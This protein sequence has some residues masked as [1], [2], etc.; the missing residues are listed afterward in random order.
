MSAAVMRK[1]AR[2]TL[3]IFALA[4]LGILIFESMYM[5]AMREF[6]D[7]VLRDLLARPFMQRFIRTLVGTDMGVDFTPTSLMTLGFVH[8]IVLVLTWGLLI[9]HCTRVLAGEVDRGTADIML[10]LPISRAT[11]YCS[12][13]A[14]WVLMGLAI[15][16]APITGITIGQE[17][18]PLWEPIDLGRLALITVNFAAMYLA[19]GGVATCVSAVSNTRAPAIALLIGGLLV[20]MLINFLAPFFEDTPYDWMNRIKYIGL[21]QY[22]RPLPILRS[23]ALPWLDIGVLLTVGLGAWTA[24]LLVYRRRDIPA[25]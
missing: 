16:F 3:L 8:P 15:V 2:D 5:R 12:V 20:S 6:G 9:T 21:L 24:G 17:M 19:V 1:S 4:V 22:Y 11:H 18:F 25:A 14:V 10:S 13:S 23:N 7:G